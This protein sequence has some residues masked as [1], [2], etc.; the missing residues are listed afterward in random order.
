MSSHQL[1]SQFGAVSNGVAGCLWL[2][3]GCCLQGFDCA[4]LMY[5]DYTQLPSEV[6][7]RLGATYSS[8][9]DMVK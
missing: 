8:L 9:E 3:Y 6:E 1:F 7:Q 4:E 5:S 2:S